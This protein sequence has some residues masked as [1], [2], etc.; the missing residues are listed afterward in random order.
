MHCTFKEESSSEETHTLP[1][2]YLDFEKLEERYR[3]LLLMTVLEMKE[4]LEETKRNYHEALK[5]YMSK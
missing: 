1:Y 5:H 2:S 3:S 4:D